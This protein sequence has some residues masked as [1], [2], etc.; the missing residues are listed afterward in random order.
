MN[1]T[2]LPQKLCRMRDLVAEMHTLSESINRDL[3]ALNGQAAFVRPD[4]ACIQEAIADAYAVPVALLVS[5]I[6]T[7]PLPEARHVGVVLCMELAGIGR[8]EAA[9]AFNLVHKMTYHAAED[10]SNRAQSDAKFA[11][12]LATIRHVVKTRLADLKAKKQEAAA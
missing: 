2:R 1:P 9:A 3:A 10:V 4:V 6:R 11:A 8:R 7:Q 5:R 12:K